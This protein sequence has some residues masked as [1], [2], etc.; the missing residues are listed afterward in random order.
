MSHP[1]PSTVLTIGHAA[2]TVPAAQWLAYRYGERA[3]PLD[4]GSTRPSPLLDAMARLVR[5]SDPLVPTWRK[6]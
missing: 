4:P 5:L 6:P 3:H 1:R 2:W